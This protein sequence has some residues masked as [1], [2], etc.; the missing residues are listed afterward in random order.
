MEKT[1]KFY[2]EKRD[3]CEEVK[4]EV[5]DETLDEFEKEGYSEDDLKKGE[6]TAKVVDQTFSFTYD[7]ETGTTEIGINLNPKKNIGSADYHL[8][9]PKCL[10]EYIDEL[11]FDTKGYE[12]I[13]DD[14]IIAW[15]FTELDRQTNLNYRVEGRIPKDCL[16]QIKGLPIADII[17]YKE[18]NP[19]IPI[20]IVTLIG[21]AIIATVW[22]ELKFQKNPPS[23]STQPDISV[24]ESDNKALDALKKQELKKIKAMKLGSKQDVWNYMTQRG[25]SEEMKDYIIDNL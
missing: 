24:Q 1:I 20:I 12:V 16:E 17:N 25:Y 8:K 4:E 2:Y 6:E 14:P 18:P 9:I 13:K 7:E 23:K 11:E 5:D 21:T 22:M 10:A 15:H 3:D 19:F